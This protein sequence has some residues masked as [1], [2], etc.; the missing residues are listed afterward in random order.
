VNVI[1]CRRE[2]TPQG[3][4]NRGPTIICGPFDMRP[5][6]RRLCRNFLETKGFT[7]YK[8]ITFIFTNRFCTESSKYSVELTWGPYISREIRIPF[9]IIV[10]V[11]TIVGYFEPDAKRI[12]QE[13]ELIPT[14][15]SQSISSEDKGK[16]I[17]K[18]Q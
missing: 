10:T 11:P 4:S 3:L 9:P 7:A 18:I 8:D 12:I 15:R 2:T 14:V 1:V 13:A 5:L 16:V 17:D 6:E